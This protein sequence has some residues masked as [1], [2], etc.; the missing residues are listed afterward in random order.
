MGLYAQKFL[1]ICKYFLL[2]WVAASINN[3]LTVRLKRKKEQVE[4][5]MKHVEISSR[6][7]AERRGR[8]KQHGDDVGLK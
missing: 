2:I 6:R 8:E 5:Q 7:V 3:E 1:V 4:V